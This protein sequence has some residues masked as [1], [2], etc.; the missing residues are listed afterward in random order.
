M[1]VWFLNIFY[2]MEKMIIFAVELLYAL[3]ACK[4]PSLYDKAKY[5]ITIQTK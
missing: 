4:V 1:I 2:G 3:P 5:A